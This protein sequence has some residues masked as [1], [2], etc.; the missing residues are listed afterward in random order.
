[1]IKMGIINL[2]KPSVSLQVW[3]T[4]TQVISQLIVDRCN[5][6]STEETLIQTP[7]AT[8]TTCEVITCPASM[9]EEARRPADPGNT[10][11]QVMAAT[12]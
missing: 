10:H 9:K 4:P 7:V 5:I 12:S 8:P 11:T 1:M 6:S 3:T 2:D